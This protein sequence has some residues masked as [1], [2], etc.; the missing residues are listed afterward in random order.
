[1]TPEQR[2][3][4]CLLIRE[5]GDVELYRSFYGYDRAGRER[6]RVIETIDRW[7]TANLAECVLTIDCNEEV[8]RYAACTLKRRKED[9]EVF[10]GGDPDEA[11]AAAAAWIES[12]ASK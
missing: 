1:M 7:C 9:G 8:G 4:I 10:Y 5:T 11:R 6:D 2:N 3:A 12:E